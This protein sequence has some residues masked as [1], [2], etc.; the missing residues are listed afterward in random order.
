MQKARCHQ[1][2][3]APT[4]CKR[5][6]SGS[7]HS[8][9]QGSFHLSF[10]VL[11]HYRSLGSIQP[12]QMVL[13]SSDKVSPAS[14]YSISTKV[15]SCTGLSPSLIRLPKRFHSL[16]QHFR[17][18]PFSLAT[19]NR[20]TIVLFSSRYLDVSVP[21]VFPNKLVHSLQLC[22]LPHS[23]IYGS[24]VICTSPQLFAAYHVLRRLREPRHPPYALIHFLTF[25][26]ND[27]F[28]YAIS[29]IQA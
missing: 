26:S 25:C 15:A 5:M 7:F 9:S 13:A 24:K 8:L 20:I 14:P 6:V 23:D 19:T 12:Y 18:V 29:H 11:V 16:L 27:Q 17:A 1:P 22:G 3:S 21:W 28:L 4:A 2:K 10:T